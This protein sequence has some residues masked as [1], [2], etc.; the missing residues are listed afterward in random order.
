MSGTDPRPYIYLIRCGTHFC[1]PMQIFILDRDGR[2]CAALSLEY[3]CV[4]ARLSCFAWVE[5]YYVIFEGLF[6]E[7]H[8]GREHV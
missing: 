2:V 4:D 1:E 7:S 8:P 5:S 3:A 6:F